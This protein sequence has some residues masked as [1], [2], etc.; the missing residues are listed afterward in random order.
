MSSNEKNSINNSNA[1]KHINQH[2]DDV[3]DLKMKL[4][5]TEQEVFQVLEDVYQYIELILDYKSNI[6][7]INLLIDYLKNKDKRKVFM[8]LMKNVAFTRSE[9]C[10]C[11][12]LTKNQVQP[13]L[14]WLGEVGVVKVYGKIHT[15]SVG[16]P[17]KVYG[18]KWCTREHI[19]DAKARYFDLFVPEEQTRFM[20]RGFEEICDE[21]LQLGK[22][23]YNRYEIIEA[24]RRHGE[25]DETV[26]NEVVSV[27]RG[28][29]KKVSL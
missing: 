3:N 8:Y 22:V 27:L 5:E 20:Y 13:F 11:L 16:V 29:C 25:Y 15:K 7:Y 4:P 14:R 9:V 23:F 28:N 21:L 2:K 6:N 17:P 12:G 26:F 10:N 24:I 1:F 18:F 19:R